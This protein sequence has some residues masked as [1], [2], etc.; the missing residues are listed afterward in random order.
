MRKN[1]SIQGKD[2]EWKF[3]DKGKRKRR[4]GNA[5]EME[6]YTEE[7]SCS[8]TKEKG[9]KLAGRRMGRTGAEKDEKQMFPQEEYVNLSGTTGPLLGTK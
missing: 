5:R 2:H 1:N 9:N 4:R 3:V 8:E 7:K 6:T